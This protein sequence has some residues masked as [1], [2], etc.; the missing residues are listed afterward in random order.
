MRRI[1]QGEGPAPR[2]LGPCAVTIGNFDGVHRGHRVILERSI[3]R[4]RENGWQ[5]AALTFD[6]HPVRVVRPERAPRLM[7]TPSERLEL[8]ETLGLDLAVVLRFDRALMR[9]TPEEFVKSALVDGLDARWVVVGENFR[10]GARHAGAIVTLRALGE[11]HGFEVEAVEP[12]AVG[13]APVSSSRIREA[14]DAGAVG[15]ARRLLGRPFR[16]RGPVIAG[17]GIGARQ[18]VPTLNIAPESDLLPRDGVYVTQAKDLDDGRVWPAVS[19]VGLRPTFGPSER[20]VETHLLAALEAPPPRRLQVCFHR[21]LRDERT[22]AT[23]EALKAQIVEDAAAAQRFF[24]R[25]DVAAA[26]SLATG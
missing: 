3:Q 18:T 19:N 1:L 11:R 9:Q 5:A 13:G 26:L 2:G 16:L 17:R 22:F 10:F 25:L 12:L 4:A 8:F 14:V 15:L 21:R 20:S 24:E 23:P 7:T 6:P